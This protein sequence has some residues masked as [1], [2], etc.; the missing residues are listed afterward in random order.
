MAILGFGHVGI[1]VKNIQESITF[2]TEIVGLEL[3]ETFP[4][5]DP[6]LKLAFLGIDNNIIV[7]LIEGYNPSLPSEGKVHHFALTVD[8]IEEE[9]SRLKNLNVSFVDEEIVTLP[10]GAKYLFFYGPDGEWIEYMEVKTR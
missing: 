7:E 5:T 10:N 9:R 1:Q 6:S 4:H 2:Y 3:L 8:N